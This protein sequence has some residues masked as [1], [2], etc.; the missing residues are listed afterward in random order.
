M[1]NARHARLAMCLVMCFALVCV[2]ACGGGTH[3][4]PTPPVPPVASLPVLTRIT[5]TA[6]STTVQAG[7]TVAPLLSAFDERGRPMTVGPAAWTSSA[8]AVARVSSSG[9]VTALAPGSAVIAARVGIAQGELPIVVTP[10]PDGLLPLFAITVTPNS[11]NLESGQSVQLAATL[12]D[13]ADNV[14]AMRALHWTTS[15]S[16]V[17]TVSAAGLVSARAIGTAII[18]AYS[19]SIRGATAVS[20]AFAPDTDILVS[21]A[22][23]VAGVTVGD[24]LRVEVAVRTIARTDSV[25][26]EVGGQRT[27]M[28]FGLIGTRATGWSATLNL[29]TLAYGPYV[30][31]VTAIDSRQHR[32]IA[33]LAFQRDPKALGGSK[34]NPTSNK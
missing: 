9:I 2:G 10:T 18:A 34:G 7:R 8:P 21:Y 3:D 29:A 11:A 17:A 6:D 32:G 20:V 14:L 13:V 24:T 26:A 22:S 30:L 25:W 23:P 31:S 27:R 4:S 19:D 12:L 33:V 1:W 15:D 5:L 28:T 16:T